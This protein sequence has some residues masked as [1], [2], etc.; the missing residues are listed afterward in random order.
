MQGQSPGGVAEQD[1]PGNPG[2]ESK[3][4]SAEAR[5]AGRSVSVKARR[6][7]D[8]LPLNLEPIP[9]S[10]GESLSVSMHSEGSYT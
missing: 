5:A 6:R 10:Q 1:H 9:L 8:R 7:G 3:T 4:E 2:E